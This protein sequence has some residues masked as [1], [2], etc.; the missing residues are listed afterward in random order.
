MTDGQCSGP[1]LL[2]GWS[3]GHVLAHWA[4][5]ADGQTRMLLAAMRGDLTAQYPGGNAQ[6]HAD[7]EAGAARPA[8]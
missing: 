4:R 8:G 1:S 5:N 6:R 3:R 7:I 2:A